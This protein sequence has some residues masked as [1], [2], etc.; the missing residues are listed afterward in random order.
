MKIDETIDK[1]I[2]ILSEYEEMD[3]WSKM[4]LFDELVDILQDLHKSE[5]Q[6]GHRYESFMVFVDKNGEIPKPFTKTNFKS[7]LTDEVYEIDVKMIN[8][9]LRGKDGNLTLVVTGRRKKL[10]KRM[11][12]GDKA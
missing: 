8:E 3:E 10:V 4:Y 12:H 6:E 11:D 1:T 2:D 9:V 5:V 7:P